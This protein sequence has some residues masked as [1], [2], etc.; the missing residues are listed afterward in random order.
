[1]ASKAVERRFDAV[2]KLVGE[3]LNKEN[4]YHTEGTQEQRESYA[5]KVRAMVVLGRTD[6]WR[7][8][9]EG[10]ALEALNL[11]NDLNWVIRQYGIYMGYAAE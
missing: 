4:G 1:M 5:T 6:R 8:N 10:A 2:G 11:D 7:N 9:C 3:F